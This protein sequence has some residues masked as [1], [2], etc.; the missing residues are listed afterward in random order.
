MPNHQMGPGPLL[1]ESGDLAEPGFAFSLVKRY[2]RQAISAPKSRIKEWD[3]Y[4]IGNKDYGI[5]LTVD[6][7]GY[8]SMASLTILEFAQ[9]GT[10]EYA[11]SVM[12]AFPLG[13]MKM[14]SDSRLGESR[15]EDKKGTSFVFTIEA[16]KR[17][18]VCS[19]NKV[20]PRKEP[21][22]C[23]LLL[24]ETNGHSMVIATPFKKK[25]HFYYNQKI[26]NLKA[27]GYAKLGDKT[28]D[29]NQD[30]YG[31]LD[32]GRGV[33]TYRNTW[34]WSSL[35]VCQDGH[36]IGWNLG[37]GFGDTKA[38]SENMLFIDQDAYKLDDVKFDIPMKSSGRDDFMK[39]WTFRSQEG[40]ISLSFTPIY[41][42][43]YAANALL[44]ASNQH[45]V[46]G[47]FSG[48]FLVEGRRIEIHDQLG[49]A[50]KVYN[51]W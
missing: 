29:F 22:R 37:Y 31:V 6:D 20:G 30:S 18:L 38:A 17:H 51:R 35:S 10:K 28:Y 7:N 49:F 27:G 21:F 25:G 5:A 24:Q 47:T 11:K 42:R 36:L 40:T 4:Y 3:Y 33:W 9:D 2:D 48:F 45:Q 46:F 34:Y 13:K 1:N 32:W 44:I 23:D 43:H 41:D 50:E 16:G 15:Y 39:P 12:G 8:M 14:P 26:N 19:M